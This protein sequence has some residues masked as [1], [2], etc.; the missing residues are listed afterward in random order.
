MNPFMIR[1]YYEIRTPGIS[2]IF[3]RPFLHHR[4]VERFRQYAHVTMQRVADNIIG[5]TI[6]A[7]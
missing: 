3:Y 7:I 2:T 6:L 5:N 1:S 4:F